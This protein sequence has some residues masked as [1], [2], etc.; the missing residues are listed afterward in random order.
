M[1]ATNPTLLNP[2][3]LVLELNSDQLQEAWQNSKTAANPTSRWQTYLNQAVTAA[4]LPWL[5]AEED[6]SAKLTFDRATLNNI[7]EVVNGTPITLQDTKLVLIP[8][9]AEDL[10]EIRIPQEWVDIPQWVA[11]YYLA[12]QV[13][14]DAG[15]IRVWGY[16]THQKLKEQAIFSNSDRTYTLS[17]DEMITDIDVL[18]V[19]REL[20]PDE[21]TQVAVEPLADISTVQADNLIQR[22]GDKSQLLPRLAVSFAL[23]G[24][25]IQNKNWCKR[26]VE[27]RRGVAAKVSVWQYLQTSVSNLKEEFG[28]RQIELQ[29]SMVGARD[30]ATENTPA[31]GLAKQLVIA[32]QPYELKILPVTAEE[33]LWRFELRSLALGGMI[34]AGFKLRLLTENLQS[35]TGNEDVATEAVEQLYLEVALDAGESLVWEIEPTPENYR[36]EIL[37]F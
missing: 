19:A 13:N 26:L 32:G 25:L 37:S 14:V 4:F 31:M 20:C 5:Q 22:L 2:T 10:S 36:A 16:T 1:T 30:A 23:W 11:D 17:D 29:P 34:P 15:Y 24:A 9:E 6:K 12:V 28:W 3:H 18:W 21:V 35:F 7:W 27:K 8:T 33:N